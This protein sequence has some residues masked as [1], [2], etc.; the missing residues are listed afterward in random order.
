MQEAA[1]WKHFETSFFAFTVII[2]A[3]EYSVSNKDKKTYMVIT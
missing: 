2:T 1:K 3:V